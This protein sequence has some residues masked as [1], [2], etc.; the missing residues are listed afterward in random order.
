MLDITSPA[1]RRL[2]PLLIPRLQRDLVAGERA[3]LL[4]HHRVG[5]VRHRRAGEDA[6]RLATFDRAAERVTGGGAAR[7]WQHRVAV[8]QQIGMGDRVA[9]DRAVGMRR[10]VDVGDKVA[11]QNAPR[12]LGER[13]D[14]LADDRLHPLDDQRQRRV[15]AQ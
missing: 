7:H 11:R 3:V 1:W 2:A 15:D 14:F 5:A 10:H 8:R 12:R 13:R 9:V 4:H 6:D